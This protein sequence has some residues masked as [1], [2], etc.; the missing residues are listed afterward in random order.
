MSDEHSDRADLIRRLE[1]DE[2]RLVLTRFDNDD[3]WALGVRLV[4][5][6]RARQHP[7][8]VLIERH[9]HQL[10]HAVLPGATP[11]NDGW[12]ARKINVVRRFEES[13]Y[14]VGRRLEAGGRTLDA[15][16]GVDP[17]DYAAHG[18]AFP[19]RIAGVG[20]IG[21]VAVSG[22]PQADDH[23]LLVEAITAH[24]GG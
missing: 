9:G 7:V 17:A 16:W 19:I 1:D 24:L 21:V 6:A 4:D 3:A 14:L 23:S 5:L 11:D 20:V 13:S 22:L 18:G 15:D 12:A 2:A 8:T 10:F